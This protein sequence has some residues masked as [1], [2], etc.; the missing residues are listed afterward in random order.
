[1]P[2]LPAT[3]L[4]DPSSPLPRYQQLYRGLRAAIL[5]GQ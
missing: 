4:L 3:I 1:M 5:A 2:P